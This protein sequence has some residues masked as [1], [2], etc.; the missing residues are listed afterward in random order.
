MLT[1]ESSDLVCEDVEFF[2]LG[3]ANRE[4]MGINLT[5]RHAMRSPSAADAPAAESAVSEDKEPKTPAPAEA[6]AAAVPE[7]AADATEPAPEAPKEEGAAGEEEVRLHTRHSLRRGVHI[8]GALADVFNANA[9]CGCSRCSLVLLCMFLTRMLT[10]GCRGCS[11]LF[12]SLPSFPILRPRQPRRPPLPLLLLWRLPSLPRLRLLPRCVFV[13]LLSSFLLLAALGKHVVCGCSFSRGLG[14][15]TA[16]RTC[17]M[18][19]TILSHSLNRNRMRY[20]LRGGRASH[21]H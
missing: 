17:F 10:S 18:R 20:F 7:A 6:A 19:G 1:Y 13:H 15:H 11:L 14:T 4:A 12:P 3:N 8:D 9:R 2:S 16:P 21:Q 5:E